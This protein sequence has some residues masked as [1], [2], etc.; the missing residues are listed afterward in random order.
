LA[1]CERLV[2]LQK[3][4]LG[5]SS[6]EGAGSRF[7]FELPCQVLDTKAINSQVVEQGLMPS[8]FDVLLVDDNVV[9]LMVA[10]LQI[11]KHFSGASITAVESGQAALEALQGKTF[12]IALIDMVMP[13]MNGM[14]L[15]RRL[16]ASS[17]HAQM[18]ILALTANTNP[19]DRQ[20]CLD[21]G[22]NGV[23]HKPMDSQMVYKTLTHWL[24][25]TQTG[26]TK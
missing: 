21:A 12:H 22:M 18:P 15:T 8:E 11:K 7:W 1:I 9:N 4:R 3:G 2:V 16:R 19:M 5:V 20:R 13:D 24:S 23:L 26:S 6:E 25:Q 10:Q 14:E 17:E